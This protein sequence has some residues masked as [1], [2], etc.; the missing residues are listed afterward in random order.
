MALSFSPTFKSLFLY[1]FDSFLLMSIEVYHLSRIKFLSNAILIS[2]FQFVWIFGLH[3]TLHKNSIR[4]CPN[5]RWA[6]VNPHIRW[7][8]V[9]RKG[10]QVIIWYERTHFKRKDYSVKCLDVILDIY[11]INSASY[12][13]KAGKYT[14]GAHFSNAISIWRS[15][16]ICSPKSCSIATTVASGNDD[17][18]VWTIQKL[19]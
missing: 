9:I 17:F 18:K 14:K 19:I 1:I 11:Q 10:K 3:N 16:Q 12:G 13:Y 4:W 15:R 8:W 6:W 7:I 5:I 2:K